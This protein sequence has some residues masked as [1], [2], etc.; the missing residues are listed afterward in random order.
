MD[1]R[2]WLLNDE[3]AGSIQGSYTILNVVHPASWGQ[4][5]SY[6]IKM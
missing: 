3:V 2:D 1:E 5:Y 4:L 6:L